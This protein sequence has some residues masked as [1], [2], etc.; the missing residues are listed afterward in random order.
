[1]IVDMH[2]HTARGGYDSS[3]TVPQLIEEAETKGIGAVCLTEHMYFWTR[4]ELDGFDSNHNVVLIGAIEVETDMGHI[5]AFGLNR[6]ISGIHR[7]RELRRV[8]D[9]VG[10]FLIA[11]H[12]FRMF[13]QLEEFNV[14]PKRTWSRVIADA[15]AL[16]VL[17]LVDAIEVLNGGCNQRENLLALIVAKRLGIRGTGGSDVHSDR[18]VGS[19][20]TI[21][22]R[23]IRGESDLIAELKAGRFYPAKRLLN[24]EI[25]R[26][27]NDPLLD[28]LDEQD[29]C[30][31]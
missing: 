23:E 26:Y 1:M 12:P 15:L 11:A 9:E 21:F 18:G 13:F 30:F 10:G 17:G 16:P 19:F 6:Y 22:E 31:P 4:K 24:G 14:K 20:A 8:I 5:L 29:L 3:L 25:I 27:D 28:N 2:V 7:L